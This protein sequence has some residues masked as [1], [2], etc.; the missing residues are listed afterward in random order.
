PTKLKVEI[1]TLVKRLTILGVVLCLSVIVIYT[2]TR[3]NLLQGFLA[4]IT[5][6]MAML[7]EEFPV[8]LTIFMAIGAW[9][10]SKKRVLTRTPSA[11]E[12]L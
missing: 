1:R 3:G 11:I 7:P 2:I 5:L 9:R 4:G 10:I 6:A 12:T 8:V